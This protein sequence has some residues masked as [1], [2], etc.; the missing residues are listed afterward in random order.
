MACYLAAFVKQ[1]LQLT[2][3]YCCILYEEQGTDN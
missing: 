1:D 2:K 3:R